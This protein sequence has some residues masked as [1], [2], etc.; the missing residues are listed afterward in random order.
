VPVV[1]CT[2]L[3]RADVLNDL[4]YEDGTSRH[5][6][7]VFSG[8]ARNSDIPQYLDNRQVYGYITFGDDDPNHYVENGIEQAHALLEPE[9]KAQLQGAECNRR[10]DHG[11]IGELRA[12]EP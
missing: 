1:H 9:L 3:I 4:A 2:Y 10:N 7:V 8:S 5:E 6:Y 12:V 11:I